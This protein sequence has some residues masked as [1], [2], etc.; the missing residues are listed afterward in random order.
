MLRFFKP[1]L[2]RGGSFFNTDTSIGKT[3]RLN[4][5]TVMS[6]KTLPTQLLVEDYLSSITNMQQQSDA[7][8]LVEIFSSTC[9]VDPVMWGDSIVGFGQY[10]YKYESGREGVSLRV[11]FSAR[12]HQFSLYGLL[13]QSTGKLHPD[14][15]KYRLGKGC[16]YIQSLNDINQKLLTELISTSFSSTARGEKV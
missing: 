16:V 9:Q 13:V 2:S 4:Y 12:A 14:L 5:D 15:G 10:S 6:Q 1:L 7:R 3:L 11:G 8:R